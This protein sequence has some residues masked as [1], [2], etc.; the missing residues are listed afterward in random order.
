MSGGGGESAIASCGCHSTRA[1]AVE[2]PG[3]LVYIPT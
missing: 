1:Q 3:Q 2:W